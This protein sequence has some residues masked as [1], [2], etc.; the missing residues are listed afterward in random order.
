MTQRNSAATRIA[1]V[2][3]FAAVAFL[4]LAF[5]LR[6]FWLSAEAPLPELLQNLPDS[7]NEADQQAFLTRLRARFPAGTTE[8]EVS[9]A[10]L[11]QGFKMGRAGERVATYDRQAGIRDKCRR[12][13]NVR[14]SADA[15]GHVSEISG[16]YYQHCPQ[17]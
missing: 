4:F 3:A 1:L 9:A 6:L 17:H 2:F 5:G 16:G 14:W 15:A 13:G 11:E 12:S 7:L 8:A 10:L